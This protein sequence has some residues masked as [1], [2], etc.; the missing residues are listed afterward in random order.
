[1][2]ARNKHTNQECEIFWDMCDIGRKC[3]ASDKPIQEGI[4]CHD[5]NAVV[6]DYEFYVNGFWIDGLKY[7]KNTYSLD[8]IT[9]AINI[10]VFSENRCL[11]GEDVERFINPPEIPIWRR[12]FETCSESG[13]ENDKDIYFVTEDKEFL[14][15]IPKGSFTARCLSLRDLDKLP[16][17][18]GL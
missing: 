1:M 6:D 9:K 14:V 4:P 10:V 12:A 3:E 17:E 11:S 8:K 7:I 5:Y 15:E 2:K 16:K 13:K 18:E